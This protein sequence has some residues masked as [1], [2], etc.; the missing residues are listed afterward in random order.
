MKQDEDNTV[1]L[2]D[3]TLRDGSQGRGIS[4]S[5]ADKLKITQLLDD[6]GIHYVEGGWPG[7]NPK[8]SKYFQ[9]VARKELRQAKVVAFGSTCRVKLSPSAD[10]N[11]QAMRD[12]G[13]P[14]VAIFGKSWT[15]HVTDVLGTTLEENLRL[16]RESVAFMKD[17]GR[18]VIYDAEHFFDGFCADPEYAL[19]TL[20]AASSAGADWLVLCDTN[21]GSLPEWISQTVHTA[22]GAVKTRI[23]IHTHND[24]ELAVANALAA[25]N[26][27]RG[28]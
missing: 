13:T 5:M 18:E 17:Q 1:F 20:E 11:L 14:A 4:F 10:P 2:Y 26:A 27:G 23:G 9:E 8:D 16:I 21:G 12:A 3:T 6:F 7:S 22:A 25:V 15:L 28:L 24:G 19:K